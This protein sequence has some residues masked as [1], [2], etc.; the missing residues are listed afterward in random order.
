MSRIKSP[1]RIR[2]PPIKYCIVVVD[3][4]SC[5]FLFVKEAP[6]HN[7]LF[8]Q[9]AHLPAGHMLHTVKIVRS[10]YRILPYFCPSARVT[11]DLPLPGKPITVVFICLYLLVRYLLYLK[12]SRSH[13]FITKMPKDVY[14]TNH[15]A[16]CQKN[17]Q[18]DSNR[19]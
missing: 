10:L 16:F 5:C 1:F 18:R 8:F 9:R 4:P 14:Y 12:P 3:S 2:S 6:H 19:L 7:L 11:V 13:Q 17:C 15:R